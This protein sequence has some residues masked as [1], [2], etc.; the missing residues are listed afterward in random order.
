MNNDYLSKPRQPNGAGIVLIHEFWGVNQ[1]IKNTADKIAREALL[2]DGQG[3]AVLAVDLYEGRVAKDVD[4][5]RKMKDEV[6]DE[7]AMECI[8]RAIIKLQGEGIAGGKIAVW[9]FCFGGSIAFKA[10][11]A[12]LDAG[13]YII[14]YGSMITDNKAV[15][16]KIQ[17]P[18]LGIFGGEDPGIPATKAES[19][20][21]HLD[22]LGKINEVYIYPGAGHAFANE[23][24]EN[25][26]AEAAKDAWE[27]TMAF[28]TKYLK[29]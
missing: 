24:R 19:M 5:A 27:K 14:Y 15:L 10:A 12:N 13:A 1:Q 22:L 3:F 28:L 7:H 17:K 11:E 26:N 21:K 9:G 6:T 23:E 18:L 20:K 2:P 8:Q 25:Y 29:I 16:E 4:E